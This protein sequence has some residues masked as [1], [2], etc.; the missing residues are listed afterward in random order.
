LKDKI[1]QRIVYGYFPYWV[2]D[3]SALQW[4][5]LTHVAYFAVSINGTGAVTG[6]NGW[7]NDPLPQALIQAAQA[8]ETS[9]H[10]TITLFD[11]AAIAQL[12][13][14][15]TNRA[16]AIDNIITEME[17]GGADGVSIDFET[18]DV[19]TRDNFTLFISELRAGLTARGHPDAEIAIAGPAWSG[20][21]A[22]DLD[23]LLDHA[24]IYFIMGYPYFG[25]WSGRT[26]PVGKVRTTQAWVPVST[27]S[28]ARTIARYT[29]MVP[30]AKRRQIVYGVPYYGWHWTSTDDQPGSAVGSSVGSVFYN[31]ARADIDGGQTRLWDDGVLSPWYRWQSGGWH[32]VW[33]DD[34]ESLRVKYILALDQDLGGVGMWALNYDLGYPELWNVL[35]DVFDTEPP[36]V[37][38]DRFDPIP[39]ASFPFHDDRNTVDAP[40]NYFNYYGCAPTLPEYG[41]EW[42]YR[43]DVCRAGRITAHVPDYVD[44]DP[45]LHLLTA[46]DESACLDRAHLDLDVHVD[47]GMYLLV[48]DTWVTNEDV[49]LEGPYSLDVDFLPDQGTEPCPSHLVCRAGNCVCDG[50]LTDCGTYCADTQSDPQNCGDCGEVCDPGHECQLGALLP[51]SGQGV[52]MQACRRA[53]PHPEGPLAVPVADSGRLGCIGPQKVMLPGQFSAGHNSASSTSRVRTMER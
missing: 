20:I 18:P 24:D 7:P 27:L 33:Y 15:A 6:R 46:A 39:I 29:S 42:V 36:V 3:V 5:L 12:C 44:V 30:A 2:S 51:L 34:E 10:V 40:S 1:V 32:Q 11:T 21:G 19:A 52:R 28:A 4:D 37:P 50:G 25:S 9:V 14:S 47:P 48:V 16:T 13:G 53:D 35:S 22:I 43:I 45:D 49:Q 41:R 26:G 38:G 8:S 23:A 31:A 17:A